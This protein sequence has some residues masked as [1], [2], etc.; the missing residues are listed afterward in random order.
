[1]GAGPNY[2][3]PLTL[4]KCSQYTKQLYYWPYTLG[5]HNFLPYVSPS[6]S[7]MPSVRNV[8]VSLSHGLGESFLAAFL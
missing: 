7:P 3:N 8:H 4:L 2:L 5:S 6:F 1:M